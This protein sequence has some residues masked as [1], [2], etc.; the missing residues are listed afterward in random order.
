MIIMHCN[1]TSCSKWCYY[2]K[3]KNNKRKNGSLRKNKMTD[4]DDFC[5]DCVGLERSD[6]S[7]PIDLPRLRSSSD[8]DK[9]KYLSSISYKKYSQYHSAIYEAISLFNTGNDSSDRPFDSI[10]ECQY[11]IDL[12]FSHLTPK[13]DNIFGVNSKTPETHT[14]FFLTKDVLERLVFTANGVG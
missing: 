1:N 13:V 3:I 8:I 4:K 5:P 12:R 10:K 6:K 11:Y 14:G 2:S 7:A 9:C